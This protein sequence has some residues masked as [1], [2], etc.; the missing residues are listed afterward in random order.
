[1]NQPS[2]INSNHAKSERIAKILI[3]LYI[4]IN[5]IKNYLQKR[6]ILILKKFSQKKIL[7]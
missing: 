6:I 4:W 1:M 5:K 2:I 3:H 7:F